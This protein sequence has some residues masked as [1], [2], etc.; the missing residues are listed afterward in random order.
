MT[1]GDAGA[2]GALTGLAAGLTTTLGAA[3][4]VVLGVSIATGLDGLETGLDS[5]ETGV[6]SGVGDP[7]S[8]GDEG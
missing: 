4:N 2:D 7:G 3:E 5:P 8:A 1:A 6:V